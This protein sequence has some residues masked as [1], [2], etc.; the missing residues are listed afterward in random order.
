MVFMAFKL[1]GLME[2]EKMKK[3][4]MVQ[5]GM[6]IMR[7]LGLQRGSSSGLRIFVTMAM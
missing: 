4:I 3:I 2:M 7:L 6:I 5:L 1:F